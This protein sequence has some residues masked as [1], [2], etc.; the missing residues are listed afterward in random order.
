MLDGKAVAFAERESLNGTAAAVQRTARKEISDAMGVTE[1]ALRKRGRTVAARNSKTGKVGAL[2]LKRASRRRLVASITGYGRPFNLTRFKAQ[3][4]RT[5]SSTGLTGRRRRGR[6]MALAVVHEAWGR[7]QVAMGMFVLPV[8]GKPVVV[9]RG[10]KGLRGA[11]GPG[12]THV[13]EYPAI[14]RAMQDRATL[15]FPRRFRERLRYAFSSKSH[16]R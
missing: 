15:E 6:G 9:P 7:R 2:P 5:G 1:T 14:V 13:M 12:V 3:E 4:V 16:V 11:Y 10:A 8:A